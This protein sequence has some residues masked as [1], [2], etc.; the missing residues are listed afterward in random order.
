MTNSN[1]TDRN[2]DE[3]DQ[4]APSFLAVL[5]STFA[6]AFGVQNDKNRERDFKHGNIHTFIIAGVA[7]T[8][9]IVMA[10]ILLVNIVLA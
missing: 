6:A 2:Q 7:V 5:M 9:F 1:Q 10:V 4:Q 8:A 3:Q